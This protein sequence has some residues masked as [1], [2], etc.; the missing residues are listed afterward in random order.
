MAPCVRSRCGI[1]ACSRKGALRLTANG[2]LPIDG[3]HL[4]RVGEHDDARHVAQGV[5]P[6]ES[7]DDRGVAPSRSSHDSQIGGMHERLRTECAHLLQ[8]SPR[9][10][11]HSR[12]RCRCRHRRARE[13]RPWHGPIRRRRPSPVR[14]CPSCHAAAAY[15]S[16]FTCQSLVR[17]ALGHA[18]SHLEDGGL[19]DRGL[20]PAA[21]DG[22]LQYEFLH[23]ARDR[24]AARHRRPGVASGSEC[25]AA[26]SATPTRVI[27]RRARWSSPGRVHISPKTKL[28]MPPSK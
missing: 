21:V 20:W 12:R 17:K 10:P 7:C 2:L 11:R 28:M 14:I 9:G 4:M 3:T 13:R 8:P 1:A 15:P 16:P 27:Q 24:V 18:V 26:E 6:A 5:Q 19:H 25:S 23:L 22:V